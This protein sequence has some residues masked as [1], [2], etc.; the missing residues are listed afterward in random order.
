MLSELGSLSVEFTRL[1]QITKEHRYYDA[2]AR[3]TNE[4]EAWQNHTRLPGMWPIEVDAS[5]CRRV[6]TPA[7]DDTSTGDGMLGSVPYSCL[8]RALCTNGARRWDSKAPSICR[9]GKRSR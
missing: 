6:A 5:G 7:G 2:V 9:F 4:F 8:K 1:A 3:I